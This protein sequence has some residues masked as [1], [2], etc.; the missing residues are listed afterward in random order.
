MRKIKLFSLGNYQ[1]YYSSLVKDPAKIFRF[2]YLYTDYKYEFALNSFVP[3]FYS[4][5]YLQHHF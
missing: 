5:C 4:R 1:W 2:K 3:L